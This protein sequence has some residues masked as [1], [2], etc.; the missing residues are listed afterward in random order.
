ML[1]DVQILAYAGPGNFSEVEEGPWSDQVLQTLRGQEAA[2][3]ATGAIPVSVSHVYK[4]RKYLFLSHAE[5]FSGQAR[6]FPEE[7]IQILAVAT[8]TLIWPLEVTLAYILPGAH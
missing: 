7:T 8:G 4:I 2:I 1:W 3:A 5:D 6:Y